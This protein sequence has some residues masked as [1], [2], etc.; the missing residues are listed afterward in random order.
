[1]HVPLHRLPGV[2]AAFVHA[3][4]VGALALQITVVQMM[5][6]DLGACM[7]RNA[8]G[9]RH[10]TRPLHKLIHVLHVV[11]FHREG[12]APPAACLSLVVLR[13][14]EGIRACIMCVPVVEWS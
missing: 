12:Q 4:L 2:D 13:Q 7:H 1:M 14:M 6:L 10:G 3:D 5:T 9:V 11:S 8:R